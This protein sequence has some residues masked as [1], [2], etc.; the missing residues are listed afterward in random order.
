MINSHPAFT[1]PENEDQVIWKYLDFTKLI[2]LLDSSALY[3]SRADR[4]DDIFEGSVPKRVLEERG[5]SILK[6][7]SH[8]PHM[9][10]HYEERLSDSMSNMTKEAKKKMAINCWHMNDNESAAMWKLYLKSDEGIVIRSTYKRLYNAL[11]NSEYNFY[12]GKVTYIDY[13]TDTFGAH[14]ALN[15]F[16]HKR[17]SFEHEQELR[18]I[19]WFDRNKELLKNKDLSYGL[20]VKIDMSDLIES[21]SVGPYAPQW[22]HELVKSVVNKK[23]GFNIPVKHSKIN[24]TPIY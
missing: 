18:A 21:I 22:L 3:F 14:N 16:V 7:R 13:E 15:P 23:Y 20:G 9:T 8:C 10:P 17:N 11:Q 24:E 5:R 12:A 1:P 19:V 6:M 2:S 4:F